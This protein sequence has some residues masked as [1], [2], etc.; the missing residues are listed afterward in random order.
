ME[1]VTTYSSL[2]PRPNKVK[3]TDVNLLTGSEGKPDRLLLYVDQWEEL[4]AQAPSPSIDKDRA[5]RHAADANRFIDLLLNASRSAPVS[6][7]ATVRA[8]FYDPLISHQKIRELLPTQQALLG[9]MS[10]VELESTIVE[11]AKIAGLT[12][13]PPQ[14]VTRILDEAGEDDSMLPLLQYGL[15][16]TW[17]LREG[18]VMTADSYARSGGVR[19]AI[20]LTAERTF[21]ELSADDQQ[22][23]RKLFLRLVTPG[24]GQEDT[25]ARGA[26]PDDP[27][28]R[29][30]V[31]QFAGPRTRLLVTGLDRADRPTV[32]VAH[33]ALIRTWPR[34]RKWVDANREKLRARAAIVQAK[35]VWEE[36]G[37]P[38]DLLLPPGFQMAALERA[39]MLIDDP[40]DITTDDIIA[41]IAESETADARRR[42][43][44]VEESRRVLRRTL[45]GL[46]AALVLAVIAIGVGIY[47]RSQTAE[48]VSQKTE[49]ERQKAEAEKQA[50]L[51]LAKTQEAEANFREGQRTE[52]YFRGEQAKQA[53]ADAAPLHCSHWKACRIQRRRLML[54]GRARSS[55][56]RGEPSMGPALSSVN[57]R[58]FPGTPARSTA[59]CSRPMAAAS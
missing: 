47:A 26:M 24:E 31:D 2:P 53:G 46:V 29:K 21:D 42:A 7:V 43:Y 40:G 48:A 52:S 54:S 44:E 56:R 11:P 12:F 37:R 39:R 35:A 55:T 41:F 3:M 8:D 57:V 19:E 23:A 49:A 15:K 50:S 28:L 14:L 32:E 6:V 36:Q 51:A 58:C 18:K 4:Y 1:R 38:E 20:R 5:D 33:E 10:R 34:L 27:A 22:A 13:D 25:R 59:Q 45:A 30:I 9:A 17:A 16:E